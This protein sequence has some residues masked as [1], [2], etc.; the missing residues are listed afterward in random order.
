VP[1]FP[2]AAHVS[3]IV[4]GR[5]LPAYLPAY[6]RGGRV[7]APVDPLLLRL[8]DRVWRDGDAVV[9]ERL[10]RRI[11][12][13]IATFG[14]DLALEYVP[15]AALRGLGDRLTYDPAQRKLEIET[16]ATP[17]VASA[18]PYMPYAAP[19]P[20]AVFTAQPVPTPRPVWTGPALP[21]RTPLPVPA[22]SGPPRRRL[23]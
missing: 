19:S 4:D 9:V 5:P 12:I 10:E 3:V 11:R 15:V 6:V 22:S 8:A 23:G 2:P 20:R 1:V 21:R 7:F 14:S 17:P 18:T 16:P 13:P